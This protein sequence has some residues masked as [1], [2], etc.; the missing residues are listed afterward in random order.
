MFSKKVVDSLAGS[1]MIRAMF[2]EGNRLRK[3]FGA[4]NVY[5]FSIGNPEIEP[6]EPVLASLR[7]HAATEEKGT[8]RYMPNAGLE[9]VRAQ[10]ADWLTGRSGVTLDAGHVVMV[11]GAAAG[12]NIVLKALLN[13][14]RK[15]W[16]SR[17]ISWSIWPTSATRK[18]NRW[19][20]LLRKTRLRWTWRPSKR[21]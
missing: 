12:L 16:C 3:A 15:W 1:S 13:P 8:H 17:H 11:T 6:P 19:W 7:A 18:A 4:E 14:V 9:S 20:Y 21:P 2:E 5:D 10:V